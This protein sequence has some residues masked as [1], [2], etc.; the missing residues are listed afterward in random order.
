[1]AANDMR[2]GDRDREIK[3][4][5]SL[6]ANEPV[7]RDGEI[8]VPQPE[9][10]RAP[11]GVRAALEAAQKT[12]ST[13]GRLQTKYQ[14]KQRQA[15]AQCSAIAQFLAEDRAAWRRFCRLP[16]WDGYARAPDSTDSSES[17][18]Y[19]LLYAI[20][21]TDDA[22]QKKASKLYL[23][24]TPLLEEGVAPTE[25]PNVVE[26]RGG[27]GRLA[28]ANVKKPRTPSRRS[29]RPGSP[30]RGMPRSAVGPRAPSSSK[31]GSL[32]VNLKLDSNARREVAELSTP[33][34]V[35]LHVSLTRLSEED[36][37]GTLYSA[38]LAE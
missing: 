7:G 34:H 8:V 31:R 25:I 24:V 10:L 26:E 27:F 23:A 32:N 30:T 17:L 1:M 11:G 15:V 35:A 33:C 36:A 5:R 18:R 21:E 4:P 29:G 37:E 9:E 38:V 20:G 12:M 22:A 14:E 13:A 19:V 6:R 2:D 3:A 28:A 16:L